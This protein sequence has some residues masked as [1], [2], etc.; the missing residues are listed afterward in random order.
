MTRVSGDP[1]AGP[2]APQYPI[3]SV[4]RTLRVLT[5]LAAHRVLKL[6]EIREHLGVGQSTAHRLMSMLVYRGFAVQDPE[7]RA[8][9]PGLALAGFAAAAADSVDLG[10]LARPPL[11]WLARETG[12]TVH[13]GALSG[14]A[15]RYLDVIE[16]PSPLRVTGRVGSL[17]PAHAT[18]LGKAML[19]TH[20][21]DRVRQLYAGS[22]LRAQTAATVTD[23]DGLLAE[24]AR[25]RRRG[26]ARNRG[27]MEV[28]VCSVGRA[29]AA[30]AAWPCWGLSVATPQVRSGPRL[31][32]EHA[33]L[34]VAAADRL[35]T[36]LQSFC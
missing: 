8:Y 21:D 9:R 6:S 13:L 16:S 34:L 10:S 31:E 5:H 7:T 26:W 11:E 14:T 24:L 33:E 1:A 28:G 30:S 29:V 15:V 25:V 18:S 19:A 32:R 23:L 27:E 4:D 36:S 12:E 20:D 2:S 35:A 3:E 17:S 22:D